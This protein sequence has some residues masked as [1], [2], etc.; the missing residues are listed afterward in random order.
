MAQIAEQSASSSKRLV[1]IFQR[2]APR[3]S[4]GESADYEMRPTIAVPRNELGNLDGFFGLHPAMR[5]LPQA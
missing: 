3:T 4:C 1:I 2:G 5:P